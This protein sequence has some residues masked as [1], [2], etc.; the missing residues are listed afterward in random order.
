MKTMLRRGGNP[1][2][3]SV[4]LGPAVCSLMCI[5]CLFA[6]LPA[7]QQ[8]AWFA[9]V[10]S[11]L[12]QAGVQTLIPQDAMLANIVAVKSQ[13]RAV[14]KTYL[15]AAQ[16]ALAAA[17]AV[18]APPTS[19]TAASSGSTGTSATATSSGTATTA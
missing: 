1:P 15:A 2:K 6:A 11:D 3:R 16:A 5:L 19:A 18:T 17:A 10:S 4:L 8:P 13:V 14:Q 9:A 12:T 7:T